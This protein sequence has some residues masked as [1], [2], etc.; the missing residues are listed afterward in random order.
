MSSLDEEL[1]V[2]LWIGSSNDVELILIVVSVSSVVELE[3][4]LVVVESESFGGRAI[5]SGIY[6]DGL[7]LDGASA[8]GVG[9]SEWLKSSSKSMDVWFCSVSTDS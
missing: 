7:V 1:V 8:T 2:S 6:V 9:V 5:T 4:I 3:W